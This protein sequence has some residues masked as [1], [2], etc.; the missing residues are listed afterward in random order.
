MVDWTYDSAAHLLRRAGFGAPRGQVLRAVRR[1]RVKTVRSLLKFRPTAARYRGKGDASESARWWLRR[2]ASGRASLQEKLTLFWHGHFATSIAK[3][4]DPRLLSLQNGTL[5]KFAAG[6]FHDLLVAVAKDPAM[7]F[8]LDTI[9]NR[10]DAPNENFARELLELFTLG[11]VDPDGQPNYTQEDV[12][13]LARCFT[14]WSVDGGRFA[15]FADDHDSGEKTLFPGTPLEITVSGDDDGVAVLRHLAASRTC[16]LFLARKLWAFFAYPDPER[17]LVEDLADVY[18]ASGGSIAA[19]VRALLLRDEFHSERALAE[20]VSSPVEF[21]VGTY[22]TLGTH[23]SYDDLPYRLADMGQEIFN[24]PNVAGWP[25]GLAWMNSVTR[26][27]RMRTTWDAISARERKQPYVTNVPRLLKA[28][29]RRATSVDVVTRVLE[30]LGV[31]ASETTR[32]TLREYLDTAPDG[33]PS[34]FDVHDKDVVDQPLR[35]LVGVVLTL[36]EA[37]LA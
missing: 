3:V 13:E 17:A 33:A 20:H 16:A 18:L 4:E 5:R 11:V 30:T 27:H 34:A 25:G 24:P 29:P 19:L 22:R 37:Y 23:V 32:E 21:A 1:G 26:F 6:R 14:G 36:P 12:R 31:R 35:G 2:M 28:L 10:K 15:Y 7:I 8:W 9:D